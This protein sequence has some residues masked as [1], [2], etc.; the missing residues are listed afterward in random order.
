MEAKCIRCHAG[1]GPGPFQLLTDADLTRHG[2]TMVRAIES[3]IMP[4]WLPTGPRHFFRDDCRLTPEE[5]AVFV[6]WKDAGFPLKP[7]P[8]HSIKLIPDVSSILSVDVARGWIPNAED[9]DSLRSFAIPLNNP[10]PLLIR[11]WRA[12]R[13]EPTFIARYN[14]LV[15]E[16]NEGVELD[17]SDPGPGYLRLGDLRA[18]TSGSAGA[19]GVDG[20]FELPSG[21]AIQIPANATLVA[22]VRCAGRGRAESAGATLRAIP[23]NESD[24]V[25]RE[26]A[27]VPDRSAPSTRTNQRVTVI[28][29]PLE[30]SLDLVAVVIRP[31]VRA[32]SAS[33]RIIAES[34][35][36]RTLVEIPLYLPLLDRGYVLSAPLTLN[37]GDRIQFSVGYDDDATTRRS[38]PVAVLLV[39]EPARGSVVARETPLPESSTPAQYANGST[40]APHGIEFIEVKTDPPMKLGKTEVTQRQFLSVLRRNPSQFAADPK[41]DPTSGHSLDRPVDSITWYDAA[42]FCNEISVAEGLSPRYIFHGIH[43]DSGGSIASARVDITASHGYRLPSEA[44]WRLAA[45]GVGAAL[46]AADGDR[47]QIEAIAW[48][49]PWAANTSHPVGTKDPNATGFRDLIGNVWEWCEDVWNDPNASGPPRRVVR[50]GAWCDGVTAAS[51]DFRSGIPAGTKNSPFGFRVAVDVQPTA[52]TFAP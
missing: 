35:E 18:Q 24:R 40:P 10:N 27:I 5:I 49:A 36:E 45:F 14:L 13:D 23:A 26:F 17:D 16:G 12:V 25:V 42:E 46:P 37:A 15:C 1:A 22:E 32:R 19:L 33:I 34:S 52:P 31:D 30:S 6:A 7:L 28:T 8:S 11:G 9:P 21:F 4:P 38:T 43:R 3:G 48:L 47:T 39:A 29:E 41:P 51:C 50:G 20:S 2:R 44:E